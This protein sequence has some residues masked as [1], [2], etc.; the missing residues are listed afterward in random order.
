MTIAKLLPSTDPKRVEFEWQND[1]VVK[2]DM[3]I[4]GE[5][6]EQQVLFYSYTDKM[7]MTYNLKQQQTSYVKMVFAPM[8]EPIGEVGQERG[9]VNVAIHPNYAEAGNPFVVLVDSNKS[10]HLVK[11][12]FV[13]CHRDDKRA[14]LIGFVRPEEGKSEI[15]VV[16]TKDNGIVTCQLMKDGSKQPIIK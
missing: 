9:I 15:E 12:K 14:K 4:L 6:D 13:A 3:T 16:A 2:K 11:G 5:L 7:L 1:H 10:A 8:P